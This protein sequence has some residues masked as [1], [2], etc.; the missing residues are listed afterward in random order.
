MAGQCFH[1]LAAITC[2][3]RINLVFCLSFLFI[4]RRFLYGA[5]NIEIALVVS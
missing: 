5:L 1:I 3:I 4:N 2:L